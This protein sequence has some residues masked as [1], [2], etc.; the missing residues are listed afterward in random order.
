VVEGVADVGR[1][2]EAVDRRAWAE[3]YAILSEVPQGD[4]SPED[5]E[6]LADAAWWTTR[7]DESIAARQKAYTGYSAAG[8]DVRAGGM[9]LRLAIEHFLRGEPAV[10]AGWLGR[11]HRHLDGR[12]DCPEV[13]AL[14]LV[15]AT[16]A[17]FGGDLDGSLALARRG[18]VIAERIGDVDLRAMAVHTEGL[19]L[20][21]TGRVAEGVRLLDEAM[22]SAIAGEL[23]DY[24]TGVIYCN[25]IEACLHVADVRRAGEWAEAASAWC[26]SLQDGSIYPGICR[27]H[28]AEVAGLRGAWREAE[29]EAMRAA[30]E[31][32]RFDPGGA[33]S[34]F[35][36]VGEIRR[37]RGDAAGAEEAFAR[38][39]DLGHDPQPGLA[40]LRLGQGKVEA[41]HRALRREAS[42]TTPPRGRAR[43]LA[44]R[45][46]VAI[47]AGDLEDARRASEELDGLSGRFSTQVLRAEATAARGVLLLAEGRLDEAVGALREA[48]ATWQEL[49]LPYEAARTRAET[50][51]ALLQAG[52]EEDATLALR[53]AAAAFEGL[54]ASPDARRVAALIPAARDLPL[55]LTSREAE[56]LRLV[57]AGK[58]NR[59]IA[60]ELFI[61]EHTVARHLQNMFAKLGVSTRSAATAFAFEHGLA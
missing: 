60:A 16:V 30:D 13:A 56:V 7:L 32:I 52:D 20:I 12:D 31:L 17:R 34:A 22:T 21:A 48:F 29:V 40:L 2:R 39:G 5:L 58:T 44:A 4:L 26:E 3:A 14:S 9:A 24:Y 50:G 18:A 57:A 8:E 43:M 45:V 15:E 53:A 54:G 19:A 33:A 51:R 47:A 23:S 55:G 6:T 46:E 11:A 35:Y 49:R 36:Q 41:A 37:R 1:A 27:V 61:S 28:R 59:E 10:G 42:P 25:V 38:A